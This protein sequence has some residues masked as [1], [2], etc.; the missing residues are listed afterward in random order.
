MFQERSSLRP[1]ATLLFLFAIIAALI[2][3]FGAMT[4]RE[5]LKKAGLSLAV[6]SGTAGIILDALHAVP[7]ETGAWAPI[8][9]AVSA[10]SSA[11]FLGSV[12]Y[13]MILGHWYLVVPTLPNRPLE[14]LARIIV[15]ATALKA[16]TIG[17]VF[18]CFWF[19]GTLETRALLLRFLRFEDLFFA[20]RVLFGLLGPGLLAYMI[21]ET[22]RIHSTQSATGLLYVATVFVLIGEAFS[23]YLFYTTLLPV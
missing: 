9:Y 21:W 7:P 12:I 20:A 2:F 23:H 18:A 19:D 8:L 4:E 14:S 5:Y 3:V 17:A 11:L 1:V 10:L 15:G 6:I 16:V 13:A 22:V